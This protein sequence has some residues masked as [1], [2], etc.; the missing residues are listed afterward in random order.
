MVKET[1]DQ[2]FGCG[3]ILDAMRFAASKHQHQ[4]R[5]NVG[6]TPYINHPLDV[7]HLLWF[8][9]NV[10]DERILAAAI[11]HDTV[12]DTDATF[13]EIGRRFGE[14]IAEMVAEVTDD[15]S[16]PVPEQK[17]KQI[18]HAPRL[19]EHAKLIKLADK[20]SNLRDVWRDPP[21]GWNEARKQDYFQWAKSVVDGCRNTNSSLETLFDTIYAGYFEQTPP[22]NDVS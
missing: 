22:T 14:D 3:L 11:L 18:E 12:E 21:A 15:Q 9:G 2:E 1:I 17:R 13:A 19:S 6:R 5:K 10:R 4:R 8:E 7:A 20:I 16:L